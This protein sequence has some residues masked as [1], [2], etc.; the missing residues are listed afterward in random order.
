MLLTTETPSEVALSIKKFVENDIALISVGEETQTNIDELI[1]SLNKEGVSFIGAIFPMIIHN[2]HT[3]KKGIVIHKLSNVVYLSMIKNISKEDYTIP[4][5]DFKPESN[6]SLITYVDGLTSNISVFLSNLYENYG[7]N[8]NYI[9]GGAGSLSLKQAPCVFSKDGFFQDA[10][11][12]CLTETKSNIG[13]KHGWKKL[14]GPFIVTKAHH[15]T[16]EEIN[17]ENPFN[18]YKSIV[19]KDAGGTITNDNFLDYSGC[20][21]I[22]IIK[23]GVD[24]HIVRDPLTVENNN[25]IVCIG[26]IEENTMINIMKGENDALINAAKVATEEIVS[27]AKNAKNAMVIDCITRVFKLKDDFKYELE[28]VYKTIQEK[29]PDIQVNGALT[30]GEISSYGNGYIEFYNR[31]IVVGLLE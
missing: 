16:I 4:S 17:W 15:N 14:D 18:I 24:H 21:P 1:N 28:N 30:L 29:Y 23:D 25:A 22:G 27:K 11:V 10:A 7:M 6:Y 26:H 9:G 13:V 31:T 12:V 20:Y 8:T 2:D 19:E 5:V 3:S